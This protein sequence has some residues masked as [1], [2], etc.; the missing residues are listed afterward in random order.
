MAAFMNPKS[1]Q[2]R[3]PSRRIFGS[4]PSPLVATNSQNVQSAQHSATRHLPTPA[5]FFYPQPSVSKEN[6]P[7]VKSSPSVDSLEINSWKLKAKKKKSTKSLRERFTG[8]LNSSKSAN[9]RDLPPLRIPSPG[10]FDFPIDADPFAPSP[11]VI[12]RQPSYNVSTP[13]TP[14][15][16]H[17]PHSPAS[18]LLETPGKP[19]LDSPPSPSPPDMLNAKEPNHNYLAIPSPQLSPMPL[20]STWI[21]DSD[22]SDDKSLKPPMLAT[23][24]SPN[25]PSFSNSNLPSPALSTSGRSSSSQYTTASSS[26]FCSPGARLDAS[27]NSSNP[28]SSFR[29]PPAF[30]L[31]SP[32]KGRNPARNQVHATEGPLEHTLVK[33]PSMQ[34]PGMW[35][36]LSID[37]HSD[38]DQESGIPR[39][40]SAC[41]MLSAGHPTHAVSPTVSRYDHRRSRSFDTPLPPPKDRHTI[42]TSESVASAFSLRKHAGQ[43]AWPLPPRR[44]VL[45]DQ[46]TGEKWLNVSKAPEYLTK[47]TDLP[48]AGSRHEI[49]VRRMSSQPASA[50]ACS[51]PAA[52]SSQSHHTQGFARSA[53]ASQGKFIPPPRYHSA[54]LKPLPRL[55]SPSPLPSMSRCSSPSIISETP[56]QLHARG[57]HDDKCI[58]VFLGGEALLCSA[59]DEDMPTLV[60]LSHRDEYE[61]RM[62]A[63]GWMDLSKF[64]GDNANV[65]ICADPGSQI[66]LSLPPP[67]PESQGEGKLKLCVAVLESKSKVVLK[68]S[69]L[70]PGNLHQDKESGKK[71]VMM[72]FP[73]ELPTTL[74]KIVLQCN[75]AQLGHGLSGSTLA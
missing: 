73:M 66:S 50:S 27:A 36:S 70:P 59:I 43:I 23:A 17:S 26:S 53:P 38:V 64:C 55:P 60:I 4:G 20:P 61:L 69:L 68:L 25:T 71:K 57:R 46:D 3:P 37:G 8:K 1:K 49:H 65:T 16:I 52:P 42:V 7:L 9:F 19:I 18:A 12:S 41:N 74:G 30:K 67:V 28:P 6:V 39:P 45:V 14:S 54:Y 44:T 32:P 75:A 58:R 35:C 51:S 72:K 21:L 33:K 56:S 11:T 24:V 40:H 10:P 13:L 2:E 31:S 22:L 62:E 63:K 5:P 15:F 34:I 29:L 47:D 48:R